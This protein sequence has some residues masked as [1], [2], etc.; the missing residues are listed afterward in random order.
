MQTLVG[1]ETLFDRKRREYL[2]AIS[3]INIPD[4]DLKQMLGILD[5]YFAQFFSTFEEISVEEAIA[6]LENLYVSRLVSLGENEFER[7]ENS[8]L[9]ITFDDIGS[10]ESDEELSVLKSRYFMGLIKVMLPNRYPENSALYQGAVEMAANT[11]LVGGTTGTEE[12]VFCELMSRIFGNEAISVSKCVISSNQEALY[13]LITEKGIDLESV[14]NIMK[15]A[16]YNFKFKR[17]DKQSEIGEIQYKLLKLF[18]SL[19]PSL[20]AVTEFNEQLRFSATD[21]SNAPGKYTVLPVWGR[22]ADDAVHQYLGEKI[23]ISSVAS[24]R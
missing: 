8:A 19:N 21:F 18:L 17:T 4:K 13:K 2:S 5:F 3:K 20:K 6:R 11:S 15:M 14:L 9:A 12:F 24:Q 1:K 22:K 23:A 10:I 7:E 16:N